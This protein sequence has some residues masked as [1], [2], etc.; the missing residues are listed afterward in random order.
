M[1]TIV[2]KVARA[3]HESLGYETPWE[4]CT[5]CEDA[6]RA[7]ISAIQEPDNAPEAFSVLIAVARERQR[8]LSIIQSLETTSAQGMRVIEEAVR[9]VRGS[10]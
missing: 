3:I 9:K 7:A 4:T 10:I 8:C 2:E 6:A 5:Q 1:T